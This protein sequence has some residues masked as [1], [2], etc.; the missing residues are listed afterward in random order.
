MQDHFDKMR[1][2]QSNWLARAIRNGA[3]A[4][5]LWGRGLDARNLDEL[6]G[7]NQ[8]SWQRLRDLQ[9]GWAADWT[10]WL[11]YASTLKGANTTSKLVEREGNILAQAVAQINAQ[12][13]DLAGLLENI[14]VGYSYWLQETL[15]GKTA[16]VQPAAG[17]SSQPV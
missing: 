7:M 9:T 11:D 3:A 2:I 1:Q 4:A 6:Y 12:A 15:A 13:T 10:A 17:Y 5:Q 16:S 14:D 8:A